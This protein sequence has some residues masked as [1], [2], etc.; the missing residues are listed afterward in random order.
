MRIL[1][2]DDD[3]T[4]R[5]LLIKTMKPVGDC[6]AACNGMEAWESFLAGHKEGRP[7]DII[8]LDIMMPE[9]NGGETLKRIREYEREAGLDIARPARIAMATTM[10]D[11]D[12]IIGSFHNQCDAYITKPYNRD[13]LFDSLRKYG[14][15]PEA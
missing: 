15:L 14:M 7:Y 1:I 5:K 4:S 3:V 13:S 8:L 10:A 12:S 2:A 11:R 9:M 6:D